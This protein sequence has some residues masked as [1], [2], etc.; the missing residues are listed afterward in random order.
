[1]KSVSILSG[2]VPPDEKSIRAA[3]QKLRPDS[4]Q[5]GLEL[6]KP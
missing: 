3:S 5:N 4:R 2:K 1:M 6:N